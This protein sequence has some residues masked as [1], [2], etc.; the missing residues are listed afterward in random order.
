MLMTAPTQ[1]SKNTN[2][3]PAPLNITS[4]LKDGF[5]KLCNVENGS[6]GKFYYTH[7]I[8]E[9]MYSTHRSWVYL[10]VV[11]NKIFKV[12]ETGNPLGIPKYGSTQPLYGT[13]CRMGRLAS[14]EGHNDTDARI[15]YELYDFCNTEEVSI[16]VKKCEQKEFVLE[17]AG[18]K[19]TVLHSYHKDLEVAMLDYIFEQTGQYPYLNM[20]RK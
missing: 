18:T 8:N 17:I 16:Y 3:V 20:C 10:I 14:M 12:G 11:N 15:R 2:V 5:Q 19:K 7:I 1:N 6:A 9:L 13:K 4:Y